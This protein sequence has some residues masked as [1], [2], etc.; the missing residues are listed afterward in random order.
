VGNS[1]GTEPSDWSRRPPSRLAGYAAPGHL[2][3]LAA[4][5]I[6][7]DQAAARQQ[8]NLSA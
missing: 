7:Q 6:L 3:E 2:R 4:W 5:Y 8:Y 1:Y